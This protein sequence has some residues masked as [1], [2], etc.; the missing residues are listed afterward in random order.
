MV[1]NTGKVTE[2]VAAWEHKREPDRQG[3]ENAAAA[4]LAAVEEGVNKARIITAKK[5]MGK[6]AL[7]IGAHGCLVTVLDYLGK[8]I[9]IYNESGKHVVAPVT[10]DAARKEWVGEIDK[11]TGAPNH[12]PE[13][14]DGAAEVTRVAL[15][16][17]GAAIDGP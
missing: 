7:D 5:Q 13:R 8:E 3:A 11:T 1:Y 2:V 6:R 15:E 16:L 4:M 10:Y 14:K 17:L 9:R 12:A